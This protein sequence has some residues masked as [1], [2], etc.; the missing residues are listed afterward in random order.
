MSSGSLRA[1]HTK[2]THCD[3]FS[4]CRRLRAVHTVC[5]VDLG[6][7]PKSALASSLSERPQKLSVFVDGLKYGEFSV[8]MCHRRYT[9]KGMKHGL[10]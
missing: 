3:A 10:K 7:R 6:V 1:V 4:G 9:Q 2:S 8:R 5:R